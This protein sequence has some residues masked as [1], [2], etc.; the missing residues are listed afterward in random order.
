ME[1]MR[2]ADGRWS[3]SLTTGVSDRA[4][5]VASDGDG[6]KVI[7]VIGGQQRVRSVFQR[8]GFRHESLAATNID[9]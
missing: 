1:Q 8:L 7:V 3:S 2:D 4:F 9:Y 5:L 6:S